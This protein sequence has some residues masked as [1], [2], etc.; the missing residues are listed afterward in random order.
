MGCDVRTIGED[1]LGAWV[2]Q[3]D[4]GFLHTTAEGSADYLRGIVDL[5]RT[6]GAF[7]GA[8]CVG[9]LRSFATPLTVPGPGEVPAAA[10]TNV[11]VA[12]THR[13]R[14]LLT[15]M[16]AAD[17]R[18]SVE[19]GEAVGILIASEYPIYGRFGYGPA[20]DAATYRV[21]TR[22]FRFRD[23]DG[24]P[25]A[26]GTVE[27]VEPDVLRAE[28]PAVYEAF[29]AAQP[30]SIVRAAHWW[31]RA[32]GAVEVPGD[33]KV[34]Q[35]HALYRSAQGRAE[36]F[37]RYGARHEWEGMVPKGTM[38]IHDLVALT[39]QA[40]RALWSYCAGVDLVR[41]LEAG[42]RPTDEVLPALLHDG[43][44]VTQLRRHDF[45]WLR[46]LDTAAALAGRRYAIE[47]R[48]VLEV[49]DDGGPAGGRF[50]LEGDRGE[51]L[52]SRTGDAADLVLPVDCLGAA[53]LGGASLTRLA[54]AGRLQERRAGTLALAELMFRSARDPWCNTWF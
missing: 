21:D 1:E 2:H 45:V 54:T 25:A 41:T 50:A 46:I 32:T 4:I 26:G 29:R 8:R 18:Q 31:E 37:V 40:Y 51:A 23:G 53:Y 14:G 52:C 24:A 33:E 34:E 27:L 15:Q 3:R 28:A 9:T 7:D 20:V 36:G 38:E 39:P 6:W 43:R 5:G 42:A 19:L 35:F 12:P 47:G 22:G 11:T 44:L 30:G 16:I 13:R 10:L 49:L 48:L 17:L